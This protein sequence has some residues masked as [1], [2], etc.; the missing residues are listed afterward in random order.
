[1]LCEKIILH[2]FVM[3]LWLFNMIDGCQFKTK[4][5]FPLIDFFSVAMNKTFTM[6]EMGQ[7]P[8]FALYEKEKKSYDG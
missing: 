5:T 8:L 3:R 2:F 4:F 7:K 6:I 1:M